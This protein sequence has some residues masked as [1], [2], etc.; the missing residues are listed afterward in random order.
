MDYYTAMTLLW[1][2]GGV[3][4][5]LAI[6]LFILLSNK[7]I[8]TIVSVMVSGS[9][10]VA[11][12]HNN[13][14]SVDIVKARR[15][16]DG[17]IE[18]LSVP[19]RYGMKFAPNFDSVEKTN[20]FGTRLIHF[21]VDHNNAMSP[22]DVVMIENVRK[23]FEK[24]G[25]D[26]SLRNLTAFYHVME[27]YPTDK[28]VLEHMNTNYV[29]KAEHD[30]ET[31]ED[32]SRI[33]TLE[34]LNALRAVKGKLI[35]EPFIYQ[36]SKRFLELLR[37]TVS[38]Q[39]QNVIQQHIEIERGLKGGIASKINGNMWIWIIVIVAGGALLMMAWPYLS[40]LFGA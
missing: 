7:W 21:Y 8:R 9:S 23:T 20:A 28:E 11:M 27:K 40:G 37:E 35:V 38:V 2:L 19:E 39:V 10:Y 13:D 32:H 36:R 31:D 1:T 24:A 16:K 33:F 30:D 12:I 29:K 3:A 17:I 26:F 18:L 25:I 34:T 15:G 14:N 4:V 6:F 5:L 22:A